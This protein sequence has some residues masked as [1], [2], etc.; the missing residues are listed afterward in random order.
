MWTDI[1]SDDMPSRSY[2]AEGSSAQPY[3]PMRM[4]TAPIGAT[5]AVA[6]KT[7]PYPSTGNPSAEATGQNDGDGRWMPPACPTSRS[8]TLACTSPEPPAGTGTTRPPSVS[9]Y[10]RCHSSS[11]E[12][13]TGTSSKL[14]AGGGDEVIHS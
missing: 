5:I 6:P 12:W 3:S 9:A 10:L 11:S 2:S 13:T 14:C 8:P 1:G 7:S 4:I